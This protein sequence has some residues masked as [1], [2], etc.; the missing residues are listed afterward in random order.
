MGGYV[1]TPGGRVLH[2]RHIEFPRTHTQCG[3]SHLTVNLQP[4]LHTPQQGYPLC[5]RCAKH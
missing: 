1:F 4:T 3:L 5:R 2:K